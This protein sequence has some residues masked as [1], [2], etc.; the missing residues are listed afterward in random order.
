[1]IILYS[2]NVLDAMMISYNIDYHGYASI[3]SRCFNVERKECNFDRGRIPEVCAKALLRSKFSHPGT[4][5]LSC[6]YHQFHIQN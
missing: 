3:S 4:L 1:M 5:V 6:L 2:Y